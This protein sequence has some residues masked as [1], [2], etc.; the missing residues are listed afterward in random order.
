MV[1]IKKIDNSEVSDDEIVNVKIFSAE[2][3]EITHLTSKNTKPAVKKISADEYID[4]GCNARKKTKRTRNR[5]ENMQSIKKSFKLMRDYIYTNVTTENVK[6]CKFVTLT[7]KENCI[8]L[9]RLYRN[10]QKFNAKMRKK[11]Q[12]HYEY[13][14]IIEPQAR[15][16][17]HLHVIMIFPEQIWLDNK[18]VAK[19]WGKGHVSIKNLYNRKGLYDYFAKGLCISLKIWRKIRDAERKIIESLDGK[20]NETNV[21]ES[22]ECESRLH[23]YKTYSHILRTSRGI[24][25]PPVYKMSKKES[26]EMAENL[27]L[28]YEATYQIENEDGK[29]LNV[30]NKKFYEKK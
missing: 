22:A 9:H 11:I 6:K 23:L 28:E 12:S 3:I 18:T 10:F 16:A 24:K 1:E 19:L 29:I 17:W 15:G 14:A 5:S 4:L 21:R 20:P 27:K 7:Y 8:D 2:K 25:K 30:I 13:I 26:D